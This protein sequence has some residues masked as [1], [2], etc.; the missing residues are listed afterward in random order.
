MGIQLPCVCVCVCL[1]VRADVPYMFVYG[2]DVHANR[3]VL[4]DL[5]REVAVEV[6]Q[7]LDRTN[8]FNRQ[9]GVCVLELII[10][11]PYSDLLTQVST[12]RSNRCLFW[13]PLSIRSLGLKTSDNL[14]IAV[15]FLH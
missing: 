3:S 5:D 9:F 11:T 8:W 13:I 14:C 15:S 12:R 10:Y 7:R 2:D 6:A 4:F 1:C